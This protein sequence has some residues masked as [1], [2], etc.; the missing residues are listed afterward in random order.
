[1]SEFINPQILSVLPAI[2]EAVVEVSK[3]GKK[4][5]ANLKKLQDAAARAEEVAAAQLSADQTLQEATAKVQ[6]IEA[7][8]AKA[9]KAI[10]KAKEDTLAV[11]KQRDEVTDYRNAVVER[12]EKLKQ[13]IS[14]FE[15]QSGQKQAELDKR[16]AELE[17]REKR[18]AAVLDAAKE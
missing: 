10:E 11:K 3:G 17:I 2:G 1:M 8:E 15:Y 6:G 13:D 4:F 7:K 9:L 12:E 18:V 14:S 5:Q 16:E